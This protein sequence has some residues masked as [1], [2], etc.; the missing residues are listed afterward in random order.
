MKIPAA[1]SMLS[2]FQAMS[3]QR[4]ISCVAHSLNAGIELWAMPTTEV[5]SEYF[6]S[7]QVGLKVL[8]FQMNTGVP[9]KAFTFH[10]ENPFESWMT[11]SEWYT[12]SAGGW[13]AVAFSLYNGV[14][15]FW[16]VLLVLVVSIL[17][18][19]KLNELKLIK[20]LP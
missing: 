9:L 11:F 13:N 8:E 2:H 17:Q 1:I 19:V 3:Y 6:T 5:D 18:L 7:R 12:I 20:M 16:L 15:R 4:E 10:G 14:F